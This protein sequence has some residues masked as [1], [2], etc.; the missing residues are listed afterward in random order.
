M[1]LWND[2]CQLVVEQKRKNVT[3]EVYQAFIENIFSDLGWSKIRRE[4]V[5]QETLPIGSGNSLIPDIIIKSNSRNLFV[6]E[7]K[8]PSAEAV[9]RHEKQLISY[10]LQLKL[11]FGI[12]FGEV[13]Q[14]FYDNPDD[15]EVPMKIATIPFTPDNSNGKELLNLLK[16]NEYSD[17]AMVLYCE[18]K[19]K[20]LNENEIANKIIANLTVIDNDDPLTILLIDDLYNHVKKDY[21]ADIADIISESVAIKIIDERGPEQLS[22]NTDKNKALAPNSKHTITNEDDELSIKISET[23]ISW[24]EQWESQG[25]LLARGGNPKQYFAFYTATM[26]NILPDNNDVAAYNYWFWVKPGFTPCL[27]FELINRGMSS[28]TLERGNLIASMYGKSPFEPKDQYRRV[29]RWNIS[30]VLINA[31]SDFQKAITTLKTE[32]EDIITNKIPELENNI[33]ERLSL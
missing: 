33:R 23:V 14:V 25:L 29:Y 22:N 16:N 28:H 8:R 27:I 15:S 19:L 10:M 6:I 3:E 17:T 21:G 13:I 11:K 7:I 24:F 30:N 31:D 4:I 26:N 5:S 32:L 12:Y 18:N 20:K 9:D 1:E 2:I